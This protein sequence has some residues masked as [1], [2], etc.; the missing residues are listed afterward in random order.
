MRTT[1]NLVNHYSGLSSVSKIIF[2]EFK[3]TPHSNIFFKNKLSLVLGAK[4]VAFDNQN[5]NFNPHQFCDDTYKNQY[6]YPIVLM[7]ND[8]GTIYQ[9][10]TEYLN[11]SICAPSNSSIIS[12]LAFEKE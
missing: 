4:T 5:W 2:N 10:N 12:I 1:S 7:C 9:F 8:L 11:G 3:K 6:Y